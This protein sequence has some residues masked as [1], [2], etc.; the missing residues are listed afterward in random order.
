MKK[1]SFLFII[2]V[3]TSLPV[4]SQEEMQQD[5]LLQRIDSLNMTSMVYCVPEVSNEELLDSIKG[6]FQGKALLF[7]FW[8]T[9]CGPCLRSMKAIS[10]LKIEMKDKDLVFIYITNETSPY[11]L[12]MDKASDIMGYHFRLTNEQWDYLIDFLSF[13]GI[14]AYLVISR[15]GDIYY[16]HVGFPG[17]EVFREELNTV[18]NE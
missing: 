6:R 1:V 17:T 7:D 11:D 3:L 15:D 8:A 9:W 12:W 16:K 5:S 10:P 14:P 13:K 2:C 18:L 4:F